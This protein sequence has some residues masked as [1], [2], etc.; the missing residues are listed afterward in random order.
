MIKWED[1]PLWWLNGLFCAAK[2]HARH[3]VYF[4]CLELVLSSLMKRYETVNEMFTTSSILGVR[5]CGRLSRC[6]PLAK[7]YDR[8]CLLLLFC[9][10]LSLCCFVLGVIGRERKRGAVYCSFWK[11]GVLFQIYCMCLCLRRRPV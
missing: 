6:A 3:I 2:V 7:K 1:P 9:C 8:E 4:C 10:L 11:L 5:G